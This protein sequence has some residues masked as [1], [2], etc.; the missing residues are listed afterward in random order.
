MPTNRLATRD[1][2]RS[3]GASAASQAGNAGSALSDSAVLPRP[4]PS[5]LGAATIRGW[6]EGTAFCGGRKILGYL[7]D[8]WA[9]RR[10]PPCR[11]SRFRRRMDRMSRPLHELSP[12]KTSPNEPAGP[13]M[14]YVCECGTKWTD[15]A[16]P[17]WKCKCGRHLVKRNRVICAAAGQTSQPAV[18][19]RTIR[20][21]AG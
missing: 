12:E 16:R 3:A 2:S 15:S 10:K 14:V 13:V 11:S 20:G 18:N 21:A 4:L 1:S 9:M 7:G 6:Q 17:S 19:V 5:R 8:G